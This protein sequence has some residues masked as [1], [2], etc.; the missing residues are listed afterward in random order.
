M[1]RSSRWKGY[2]WAVL[3]TA[4]ALAA[5]LLMDPMLGIR[6]RCDSFYVA[7][8][9]DLRSVLYDEVHRAGPGAGGSV[10]CGASAEGGCEGDQR[11]GGRFDVP[12]FAARGEWG[13]RNR[14]DRAC[15]CEVELREREPF[16]WW[17][18]MRISSSA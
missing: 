4:V 3:S 6:I 18:T 15:A 2:A 8:S 12:G 11:A 9:Q 1:S 5:R 16:S 10:R 7:G 14:Q 13:D 17:W